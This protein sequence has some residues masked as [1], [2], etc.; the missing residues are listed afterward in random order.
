MAK[1]KK[2]Q[3]VADYLRRLKDQERTTLPE[4]MKLHFKDLVGLPEFEGIGERTIS[5]ALKAFKKELGV[6]PQGEMVSKRQKVKKYLERQLQRG[7]MTGDFLLKLRYQDL[8]E[9]EALKGIGK[10]TIS[11]ALSSFKKDYEKKTFEDN[12]LSYIEKKDSREKTKSARILSDN[13]VSVMR[14]MLNQYQ[15]LG[16]SLLEKGQKEL[17]EL[18]MA[19]NFVGIDSDR[20]IEM[21]WKSKEASI[22]PVVNMIQNRSSSRYILESV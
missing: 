8:M 16:P 3:R 18:K 13:E 19:L 17:S 7:E 2:F 1:L 15:S 22:A 14:E 9:K 21:Y 12:I 10:T 20:M 11:C 5:N 4:L 6:L